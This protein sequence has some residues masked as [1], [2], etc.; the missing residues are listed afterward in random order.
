[1]VRSAA[2]SLTILL[3]LLAADGRAQNNRGSNSEPILLRPGTISLPEE[4]RSLPRWTYP[5]ASLL[6]P[7]S[8]QL[9]NGNDRG[10]LYLAAEVFLI[11][12]YA[13]LRTEGYRER[14]R[15]RTLA[16]EVARADYRPARRDT[17]F[18]YFEVMERFI[19]SGPFNAGSGPD[20]IPTTDESTYNGQIWR[21]ARET[22]FTD[23]S[24]PP[25]EDSDSYQR[26]LEFYR[27]RAIGPN[28]QWSWRNAGLEQDL[29]RQSIRKSD[30]AFRTATQ[31]LGLIL[32]NHLLGAV[33]ALISQRLRTDVEVSSAVHMYKD[34]NRGYVTSL[35]VQLSF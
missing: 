18:E 23:P 25:P 14:D 21:L 34:G 26:A 7:G 29:F 20:L 32:A 16:M 15:F 13:S 11:L 4:S 3:A 17:V 19:E 6:V 27:S 24:S 5:A 12:R 33:D 30:D 35:A 1:M 9:L 22:F 31:Y 28:F 2:L 8:G 10:A